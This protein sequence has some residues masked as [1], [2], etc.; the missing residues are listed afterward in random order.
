MDLKLVRIDSRLIHGQ[1][2]TKWVKQTGANEIIIID[3][4]LAKDDFMLS[5]YKMAAPS[6]IPVNVRS[7]EDITADWKNGSLD[8][9]KLFILFKDV[10]TAYRTFKN[11]FP[12]KEI[13]IGGLGAGPNKKKV[14]GPIYFDED[15]VKMLSELTEN[16]VEVY[17]QQVPEESSLT[18]EKALKRI[19]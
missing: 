17:L 18:F 5:I 1:V 10:N 14:Y 16:N 7:V 12:L 8:G 4:E 15:D 6:D 2:V 13:Q 11:E 19:K 9:K 3:D